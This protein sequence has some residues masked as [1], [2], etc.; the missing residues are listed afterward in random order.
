MMKSPGLK[1]M[2]VPLL[3]VVPCVLTPFCLPSVMVPVV[4]SEGAG[5]VTWVVTVAQLF[6]AALPSSLITMF[7][8]VRLTQPAPPPPTGPPA[9]F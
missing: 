8:A 6:G 9:T 2:R 1:T 3:M 5:L 7:D 4:L